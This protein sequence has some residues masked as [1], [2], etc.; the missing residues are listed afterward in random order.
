MLGGSAAKNM[1]GNV[2]VALSF[3]FYHIC[4]HRK[5]IRRSINHFPA[6]STYNFF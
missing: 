3:G 4:Y 5:I 2:N 1:G 6:V